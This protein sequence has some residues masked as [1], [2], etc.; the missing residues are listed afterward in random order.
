MVKASYV[1]GASKASMRSMACLAVYAIVPGALAMMAE[2]GV[3]VSSNVEMRS[4]VRP[5]PI[6]TESMSSMRVSTV[7]CQVSWQQVPCRI[8]VMKCRMPSPIRAL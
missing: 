4:S 6:D 5:P 7:L 3:R 8:S 1:L 2:S